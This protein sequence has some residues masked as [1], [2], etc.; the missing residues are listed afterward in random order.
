MM[1]ESTILMLVA[2]TVIFVLIALHIGARYL[3]KREA[4][5][6]IIQLMEARA[7]IKEKKEYERLIYQLG[8]QIPQSEQIKVIANFYELLNRAA[9]KY[10]QDPRAIPNP[11]Q[12]AL[13]DLT[14]NYT[15]IKNE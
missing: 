14:Y 11:I 7:S 15:I 5:I 6:Y 3:V 8:H 13:L 9:V 2:L 10:D 12:E 4:Q 1:K